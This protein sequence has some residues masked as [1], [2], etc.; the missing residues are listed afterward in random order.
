VDKLIVYTPWASLLPH[1][2]AQTTFL[3]TRPHSCCPACSLRPA[4]SADLLYA[5]LCACTCLS[6]IPV[7]A[8]CSIGALPNDGYAE[9]AISC[10]E[11]EMRM[12]IGQQCLQSFKQLTW[13]S[14]G[15]VRTHLHHPTCPASPG[16]TR[17]LA[18]DVPEAT[19]LA[20]TPDLQRRTPPLSLH[21]SCRC[22]LAMRG[23]IMEKISA[24]LRFVEICTEDFLVLL[25]H[26]ATAPLA[27]LHFQPVPSRA[28]H[29]L[30]LS[31]SS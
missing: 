25:M 7:Y 2:C 28:C 11:R 23:R 22:F 31:H 16:D 9:L 21:W 1:S 6:H 29:C 3:L 30:A 13:G 8:I 15:T 17:T 18:Q 24:L 19:A 12:N 10:V 5:P 27:L 26:A 14:P 20:G 4:A